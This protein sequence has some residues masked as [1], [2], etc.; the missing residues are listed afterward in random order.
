MSLASH[1]VELSLT[2]PPERQ[3]TGALQVLAQETE[4][5]T[6]G[7]RKWIEDNIVFTILILI[8]CA[9]LLGGLKG[10]LSRVL[11]V[12]GL[13]MVGLAYLGIATSE[14]AAQGIGSFILGLIGIHTS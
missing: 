1:I 2:A 7:L 3:W 4:V 5:S 6:G 11:T 8:A 13:S 9:V 14:N 12:G 10:N